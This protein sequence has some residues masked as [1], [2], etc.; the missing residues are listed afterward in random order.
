MTLEKKLI[1]LV[2]DDPLYLKFLEIDFSENNQYEI[3]TFAT[4]ELCLENISLNPDVVVLDYHLNSVDETAINGLQTL[5]LIKKE[6]PEL[7]IIILS[8]QDKI[9]V[10]V[11]CMK[12]KAFDY[13]VKSETAPLRL[14]KTIA[15]IFKNQEL[16]KTLKWYMEMM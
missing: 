7:P 1:F 15:T 2:D 16:E 5:D 13:I 10:A 4:G 6:K 14:Q 3:K 11:N 9:E 8:S 12:H